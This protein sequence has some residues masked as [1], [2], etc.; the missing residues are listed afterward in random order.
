MKPI[1]RSSWSRL[2]IPDL[3]L[4][5]LAVF[6][7]FALL[8][9]APLTAWAHEF[10]GRIVGVI[11]GDT[12]DLVTASKDL[13]R[14]RL[15]GID[16]PEKGQPFGQA[17]KKTLSDLVYDRDALVAGTKRDRYGRLV[18]KVVVAGNDA[19]LQMVAS[20]L[21]WHFKR[22]EREQPEADRVAYANA[23]VT[24]RA[25]HLGLW[26]D[27]N[28]VAPWDYR[29]PKH[30]GEQEQPGGTAEATVLSVSGH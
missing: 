9:A 12:V 3:D 14:V 18:G 7:L 15:S 13:I 20:G 5:G 26:S 27:R 17:A 22:Y 11:D 4:C 24:A 21:A 8:A 6:A 29:A 19:N 10:A 25:G 2:V 28:P 30:H 16:A 23:E 1:R